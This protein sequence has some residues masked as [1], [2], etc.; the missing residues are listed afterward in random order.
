MPLEVLTDAVTFL[1]RSEG[2]AYEAIQTDE[3]EPALSGCLKQHAAV[4]E[5]HPRRTRQFLYRERNSPR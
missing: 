1:K 3:D 2:A 4:E 5:D